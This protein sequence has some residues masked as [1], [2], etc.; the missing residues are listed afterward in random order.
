MSKISEQELNKWIA[1]QRIAILFFK[2][3]GCGV[4]QMQLPRIKAIAEEQAVSL[5]VIDLSENLHLSGPQMVLSAPVTKVFFEGKEIFKEGSYIN[6]D[7]LKQ[8]LTQYKAD[9]LTSE[10]E[11]NET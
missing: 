7:Q 6:F 9:H 11:K 1:D 3:P 8:L 10:H 2:T 4:C 5:K